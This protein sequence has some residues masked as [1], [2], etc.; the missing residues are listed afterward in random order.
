M[1]TIQATLENAFRSAIRDAFGI[2]DADPLVTTSQNEKFG[3][4]QSNAAMGLAKRLATPGT[5]KANPRQVAEKIKAHLRLGGIAA[6]V[7]IAG[8][9]F[10]NARLDPRFLSERLAQ[11]AADPRL[12]VPPAER[13][14]KVVVDYSGPNIAKQMHV[15]HL[16]STIIGDAISRV[17]EFLHGPENVIR[18]NHIGDWG[19]QFGMLI[20]FR[21]AGVSPADGS[22]I[23]D[24]EE[25]YR[26][27]KRRFDDDPA[28]Q[29]DARKCVVRLQAGEPAEREAWQQ[30]IAETRKEYQPIYERLNVKLRQEHERGESF[31]NP[32][33]P[34]IVKQ[35]R[36]KGLAIESEGAT[37]VF[38]DGP[39][40][41]PMI[42]EKTGGGFLYATTDLAGVWYRITHLGAKRLIYTHDARQANHFRQVFWTARKVGWAGDDVQLDYAPFG[43]MLGEDGRPF[44]TRSGDTVK[45][46]D[47]LDEAEERGYAVAK[48]KAEERGSNLPEHQLKEIG[49]AIGIGAV[50]YAD[51]SKDRISDYVFSW[52]KML[53]ME[54]NTGPYLQY[55]YAR[56]R[57]IFRKSAGATT[58]ARMTVD[59]PY[60]F[61]L[62]KHILRL[63]DVI[64]QVSRDLKP[65]QLCQY[66]YELATRFSGFY[67]NCPVLQSDEPIR[68]SRLALCDATARALALGLDLLGIEHP[69]QM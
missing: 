24:L 29:E 59:S 48:Q 28:F 61:G 16:R 18:Q 5:G 7:S 33:L 50:K 66:L 15:G 21:D 45:L 17:I 4:Y 34:D 44:K 11:A 2:D 51:L 63:G 39:E 41:P 27:A 60:E 25:F 65:H 3:D 31:Y 40:K 47:L 38:V 22:S 23:A 13:P 58:S 9:G 67:E 52:D 55:A 56:I 69:E 57:S 32:F 37:A 49:R 1:Q 19:T 42:V 46:K 26:Q 35:L 62:A 36:D 43:T 8:A 10:I 68:S 12:G 64:E 54:G 20:A 53:A 6:E 30:I 14:I